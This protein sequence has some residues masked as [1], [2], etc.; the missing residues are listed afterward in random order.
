MRQ[1]LRASFVVGL[2]L[3]LRSVPADAFEQHTHEHGAVTFNVAIDGN[4]LSVEFEAPAINVLGFE[5][6]PRTD[7]ERQAVAAADAWLSAGRDI[8]GVPR[9]AGC[10]LQS[11]TYEAPTL[12]SGHADYRPRYAFRCDNPVALEWVELW[13]LRRLKNVES[14]EVNVI[15]ATVQRQ[16]T[17][18]PGSLR[19]S[20]K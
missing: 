11:V 17:L 18:A 13:A 16:E 20:L 8:A 10:R 6:S 15:S 1:F 5:K 19:V 7:A 3:I 14:A 2:G 12:G 9:A 4:L